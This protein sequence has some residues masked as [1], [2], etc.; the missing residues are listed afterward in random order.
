M[1]MLIDQLDTRYKNLN[2]EDA[3]E[4]VYIVV[5]NLLSVGL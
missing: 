3:G 1:L 5:R 2:K 4:G